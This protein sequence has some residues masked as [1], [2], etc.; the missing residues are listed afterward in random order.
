MELH[1]FPVD[2]LMRSHLWGPAWELRVVLEEVVGVVEATVG[3]DEAAAA[4]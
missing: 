3:V 1:G 4:R 2:G